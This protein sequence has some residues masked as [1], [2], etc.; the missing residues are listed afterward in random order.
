M[1]K[2]LINILINKNIEKVYRKKIE[3][4]RKSIYVMRI[5]LKLHKILKNRYDS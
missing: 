2:F 4:F 5:S 3:K 1:C